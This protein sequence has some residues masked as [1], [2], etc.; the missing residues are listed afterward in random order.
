[1]NKIDTYAG[2]AVIVFTAMFIA[3]TVFIVDQSSTRKASIGS[4]PIMW[5]GTVRADPM[6]MD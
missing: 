4:V 1:M 6:G 5:V 3:G 2:L